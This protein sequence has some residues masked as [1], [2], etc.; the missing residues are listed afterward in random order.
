[1]KTEWRL[2][3]I[4]TA[5]LLLAA[6][7]YAWWTDVNSGA[8]EW[9]GVVALIL[10]ALLTLMCGGYFLFVSRR[11]DP[12]PEDRPD[13]E[14][15]EGAGEMGFFSPGSYFPFGI[16]IASTAA[17][18]GAVFLESWLIIAGIV[19]VLIGSGGLLFEYY[20][21]SRRSAEH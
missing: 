4:L 19:A 1:M 5:F 15:V 14:I 18:L 8:V 3:A 11:I 12:R 7:V 13:A 6:A 21:G 9:V 16:A 2:F 17:A 20:T 10:T